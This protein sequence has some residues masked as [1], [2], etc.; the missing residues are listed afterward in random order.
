MYT[1]L[2]DI[3]N[4]VRQSKTLKRLVLAAAEDIHSLEAVIEAQSKSIIQPILIGDINK[5]TEISHEHGLSIDNIEII[6][7]PDQVKAVEKSVRLVTDGMADILMK[8]KC[9]TAELLRGILNKEWGMRKGGLLSHFAL[10]EIPTY[11]KLLALTDVAINMTPDLKDKVNILEN[12][13]AFMN[14]LGWDKP[15]VALVAAIELINDSMQ[16]TVDAAAI[17]KMAEDGLFSSCSVK[18]P[19][20]IDSAVNGESA[21][22]KGIFSDVAG[23]ADLLLFPQ[24]ESGNVMYKTLAFLANGLSASVVL[25]A[26]APV[27]LTSRADSRET[28][29]NSIILAAAD[30]IQIYPV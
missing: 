29:L 9:S 13:V 7:E 6:H 10:F 1:S 12:A 27:V 2:T 30:G 24:L 28:K 11:H 19:M 21:R 22:L 8:G 18:G 15:K 14:R 16:A 23:D 3:E 20:A 5:I 4:E 25:G 17:C 26:S